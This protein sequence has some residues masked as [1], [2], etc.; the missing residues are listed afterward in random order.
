MKI[1]K[2]KSLSESDFVKRSV[3]KPAKKPE[4]A[5]A[6]ETIGAITEEINDDPFKASELSEA[7]EEIF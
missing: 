5:T 2:V 3:P 7:A 6:D 4:V 1:R